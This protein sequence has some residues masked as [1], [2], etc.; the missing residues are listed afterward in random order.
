MARVRRWDVG[1]GAGAG[2]AQI[3]PCAG[4]W[5]AGAGA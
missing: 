3:F 5:G 2:A 1:A 4:G